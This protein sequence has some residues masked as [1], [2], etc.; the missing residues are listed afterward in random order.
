MPVTRGGYGRSSAWYVTAGMM[1]S[2]KTFAADVRREMSFFMRFS[3][4]RNTLSLLRRT[5]SRGP[6]RLKL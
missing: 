6:V 1:P 2:A 4:L 3:R 5:P